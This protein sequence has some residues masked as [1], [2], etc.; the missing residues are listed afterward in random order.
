MSNAPDVS[1]II[2]TY[3]RPAH[4]SRM[5]ATIALQQ[6]VDGRF[7]LIVADD[8]SRDETAQLVER[9]AASVPFPVK[10]VTHPHAAFQL[11]RTRNEG[12]A[13]ASAPY[14]VFMDG[15]CLLPLRHLERHLRAARPDF[16]WFG[17]PL[18]LDRATSERMTLEVIRR[19]R[20]FRLM[21]W[22]EKARMHFR[23]AKANA[24]CRLGHPTKPRFRG[25]DI[26][27]WRR[28]FERINGFDEN[29][30]GWGYE[31]ND[32]GRRLREAGCKIRCISHRTTCAHLWHPQDASVARVDE[33]NLPYYSRGDQPTRCVN[34]FR[35]PKA[36]A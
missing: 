33:G 27:V 18:V 25:T 1:L 13:V 5:L 22:S 35:K 16:A 4:L 7:E 12:A 11:A 34:G 9:F 26:G 23:T 19:G 8:G 36:V 29:F 3:E 30:C 10:F 6:G 28:D 15:D 21:P 24:L 20:Y 17:Y 32:F 14:F 2:T 31:D